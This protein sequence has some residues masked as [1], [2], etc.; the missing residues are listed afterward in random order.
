MRQLKIERI[1]YKVL[2]IKIYKNIKNR[3]LQ[4]NFLYFSHKKTPTIYNGD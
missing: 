3:Y 2:K 1:K 4:D